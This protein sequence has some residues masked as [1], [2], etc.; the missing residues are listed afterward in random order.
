L[1]SSCKTSDD[2]ADAYGNFEATEVTISSETN[3]KIML[4]TISEGQKLEKGTLVAEVDSTLLWCLNATTY[5]LP[6]K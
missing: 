3:G 2:K 6:K 4:F 5:W 1:L